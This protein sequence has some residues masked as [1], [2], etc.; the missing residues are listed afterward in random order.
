MVLSRDFARRCQTAC[1]GS[2]CARSSEASIQWRS[3]RAAQRTLESQDHRE[4]LVIRDL[5]LAGIGAAVAEMPVSMGNFRGRQRLTSNLCSNMGIGAPGDANPPLDLRRYRGVR[6]RA[7]IIACWLG[8]FLLQSLR[9]SCGSVLNCLS[10]TR[11]RLAPVS[12]S[13]VWLLGF[14]LLGP[15]PRS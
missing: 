1:R 9:R 8:S 2:S 3:R 13:L 10:K 5:R 14:Y 7:M 15:S 6:R 4:A 12:V 11:H